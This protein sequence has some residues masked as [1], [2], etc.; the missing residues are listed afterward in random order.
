MTKSL[1]P[2]SLPYS[3]SQDRLPSE[4]AQRRYGDLPPDRLPV[5]CCVERLC[6]GW[7]PGPHVHQERPYLVWRQDS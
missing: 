7:E 4:E 6:Q 3:L 5:Y 2:H 1:S